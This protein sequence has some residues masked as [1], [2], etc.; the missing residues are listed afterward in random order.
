MRIAL[1]L[2]LSLFFTL[3]VF[4]DV[5]REYTSKSTISRM[6]SNESTNTDFYS[7]DK[8]TAESTV[9]WTSGFM[10]TMSRGKEAESA[11][12][13]RLDR[14][15]VWTLDKNKETYSVMSLAEFREQ[16]KKGMAEMENAEPEEDEPDSLA[17][18]EMYEWTV[19]DVSA[20]DS[21][22][23]NGWSC[24][25]AHV[26]ATGINKQDP[27]D[28]VIITVDMW[29]SEAVPGSAEIMEFT[30][31]YLEALGLD[32]L[33]LTQGL[34]TASVLYANKMNEVLGKAKEAKGEAVQS[35]VKIE[36]NRLKGKNLAKAA[37]EG[38]AEEL[39]AKVPF[40][41]GKK[42]KKEEEKPTYVLKT[43]FSSER[44][45]LSA[46]VDA[47]DGT[48]FEVPAGYKLKKK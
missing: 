14:D 8:Y 48:K 32:E 40:G 35:L 43:V 45:L 42:K 10:K 15:S 4:A 26:I 2:T 37:K 19:E 11:T 5:K 6:G 18:E 24:K 29:N 12:I 25:N 22:E 28:K 46:S 27:N 34:M 21:K 9:K 47:V 39:A 36:H 7:V 17:P 16:L 33:A 31:K 13:T 20:A 1:L 23:I 30:M 41:L 38:A 44:T 3:Q